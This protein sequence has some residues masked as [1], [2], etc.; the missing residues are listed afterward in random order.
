[1]KS[2]PG[3]TK[4]SGPYKKTAVNLRELKEIFR[5]VEKT[6]FTEVEIVQGDWRLRVE[7]GKPTVSITPASYIASSEGPAI[8]EKTKPVSPGDVSSRTSAEPKE[9]TEKTEEK[10]HFVTSPFVGTFFR[11][12]SPDSDPYAEVGDIVKKNQVLCIVEAMKLMNEIESEVEG[13]VAEI[14]V[15]NGQAVEYGENLIRIEPV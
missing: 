13:R 11:A 14:Y 5:L 4:R 9:T 7:R 12:P 2:L 8:P 15:N 10:G 6:D 1:L 3:W